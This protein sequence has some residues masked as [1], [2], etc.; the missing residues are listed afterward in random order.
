MRG[1]RK[2]DNPARWKGFL[3]EA[4]P[5]R[6]KAA[7]VV[8]HPAVP[9]A[10]MPGF[11]SELRKREGVAA[12]ALEFLCLTATRSGEVTGAVWSEIDLGEKVWTIPA[13][14]MK[15]GREH[16]VPLSPRALA[17]LEEAG[18]HSGA[19]FIGPD[20]GA[21]SKS[22]LPTTFAR[23]G[24][25]ETVH[26]LRSTFRDWAGERSNFAPHIVEICLA[27]SVGGTVER[28]YRRGDVMAKRR[29]V[30]DAWAKFCSTKPVV[31]GGGATVVPLRR[32]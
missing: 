4:L 26:G 18:T 29:A 27:H 17:I 14:R 24:R 25:K 30:M 11:M 2:G 9:F 19:V 13:P 8:H 10:E 20:G 1:Y 21:L 22:A 23:L 31:E 5:A 28:A 12:R 3:S 6:G 32:A 15:T 7:A 16:R